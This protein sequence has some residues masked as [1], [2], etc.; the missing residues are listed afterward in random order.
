MKKYSPRVIISYD[1]DEAG[2][3][4]AN[5]AFALLEEAGAEVR[6]IKME[7]AKDPDEYIKKFGADAFKKIL[8]EGQSKF[9]FKLDG[10]RKRYDFSVPEQKIKAAG[11]MCEFIA[12]IYSSIERE[13]YAERTAK[14]FELDARNVKRDIDS[15]IRRQ[16]RKR[17]TAE[18]DELIRKTSGMS[19][20][21]NM[22]YAKR[23]K[24]GSLEEIVLGMMLYRREYITA[25]VDGAPVSGEDF[26]TDYGRR[27]FE[28]MKKCDVDSGFD[29]GMLNLE[30]NQ[31]EVSKAIGL[32][33]GRSQ[34]AD[35]SAE[36]FASNVRLLRSEI[37]KENNKKN[38]DFL[39]V[40]NQKREQNK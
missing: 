4:A 22:D 14:I 5:K 28:F 23:P 6:I 39:A 36:T 19:D 16:E 40:I 3:R 20:R 29:I 38:G 31:E 9:D 15:I 7:G 1:S 2:Q 33:T 26:Y 11:E 34:L 10:I 25:K 12:G 24:I 37:A 8:G 32:M 18:R 17:K 30:F 35:N 21:V 13:V 27:L